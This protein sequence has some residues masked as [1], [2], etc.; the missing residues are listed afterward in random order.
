MNT[1]L[2]EVNGIEYKNF[3]EASVATQ[4]DTLA[5]EFD[6]RAVSTDKQPLP[7]KQDDLCKITVDEELVLTGFIEGID[8]DYN[9]TSH[10]III[11]GRSKTADII[12]STLNVF[13]INATSISLKEIIEKVISHIGADMNVINNVD[14]IK[15]FTKAEDKISP[16]PGTNAFE[17]IEGLARKR[18]VLLTSNGNGDVVITQSG[19]DIAPMALQNILGGENNIESASVSYDNTERFSKYVVK[20]QLDT[21]AATFSG[22][23]TPKAIANQTSPE[24]IDEEIR[25]SRQLVIEAENSSSDKEAEARAQWEANIRKSRSIIYS[26]ELSNFGFN[27]NI[28]KPNQLTS[29]LDDFA[30]IDAQMLVNSV[31][32]IQT[33]SS[34]RTILSFVEENAYTLLLNEPAKGNK[35]GE[36]LTTQ[37]N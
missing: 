5:G 21:S 14:G 23:V 1:I 32:F 26:T 3:T 24:I 22:T 19:A 11:F 36:G 18:Q 33:E 28:W 30:G 15:N 35:K 17:F 2:L 37:F 4:L 8:V 7:F 16:D 27:G 20:S 9:A 25:Q 29:I 12:D 6:F 13:D 31:T 10:T 34:S